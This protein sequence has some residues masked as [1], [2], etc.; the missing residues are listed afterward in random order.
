MFHQRWYK[1]TPYLAPLRALVFTVVVVRLPGA[2]V[3]VFLV[4]TGAGV[5]V[6]LFLLA[7]AHARRIR[8]STQ[9]LHRA[10]E[11]HEHL[12]A[13][14]EQHRKKLNELISQMPGVVWEMHRQGGDLA[15]TF[16]SGY[17]EKLLGYTVADWVD[18]PGFWLKALHP[19]DRDRVLNDIAHVFETGAGGSKFR[20]IAKDGRV[21]WVE[22]HAAV[23][24]DA[25]GN[26][27]GI[28]GVSMD[29]TARHRAEETLRDK[30]QRLQIALSAARMASWHWD[31]VT[32]SLIWDDASYTWTEFVKRVHADDQSTVLQA[33][34]QALQERQDVDIEFR[35]VQPD[36]A[37][38]WLVLKAKV[39][40]GEDGRPA[41]ITGVSI[42]VS[43]RRKAAEA[44]RTSEE[45]YRLAARATNDAIWDWDLA[46]GLVQ[47]NEGVRALF[48]YSAEQ[49]GQDIAW[50][51]EQIHEDDRERV[52]SGI[53]AV[54]KGGGRF[55]SDEYRFRCANGSYA[56][57]TDR[58]YID[59]NESGEAVRV[60]AAMTDVTRLKQ[61]ERERE[62]LLRLEQAARK[63]AEAASRLKDEFLATLSH[64]LRTPITPILGWTHLLRS[65][66]SDPPQLER[67]LTVIEQNARS[68]AKLIEDLLDVS[69]IVTGKMQLKMQPVQLERILR[70][71]IDSVQTAADAKRVRIETSVDQL[72]DS[73]AADPDRLQQVLWNLLSNAIKFTPGGGV[74]RILL[75]TAGNEIRV[76]VSD[77]GEGIPSEFLPH[78]FDRFSQADSTLIRAHGGLGVGLAIVRYIVELHGGRVNV[79]SLG[80]G[81]G[82]TFTVFL[83]ITNVETARKVKKAKP[84]F[85]RTAP[86]LQDLRLLLVD[87]EP[88]ARELITLML[89]QEGAVVTAAE[90]S[91]EALEILNANPPDVLISDIAMPGENGYVLLEK[92]RDMEHELGRPPTP[93]I[94]LTAFARDEDRKH[95]LQVGFAAHIAKPIEIEKLV[96]V[97][98]GI[99]SKHMG[100]AG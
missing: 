91:S 26:G 75:E 59:Q 82:A 21:V 64:E 100:K 85:L 4:S 35:V 15:T 77:T 43:D 73:I 83:P 8:E 50:R 74:I 60:I 27:I 49:I 46:T 5:C 57:V 6:V 3:N 48:G 16:I 51:W 12:S 62:Q 66:G 47:W 1:V 92:L 52:V 44:L 65:R 90:S 53:D 70:A 34:D 86:N 17:V 9:Q 13:Q 99:A 89:Q 87:D 67:G 94:A 10:N 63:Q 71:A 19:E 24:L 31:L 93:A 37:T 88:D 41:Y 38:H 78:V 14:L 79:E 69:R 20:W 68:Q 2:R 61:I 29:I 98:L 45:R 28:R 97:I 30:E 40:Q 80:K 76:V 72:P 36:D 56:T 39:F 7:R 25:E 11:L 23:L 22:T 33:I 42:E 18:E 32:G 95:A 58:A 96:S 84:R 55:W 54:V 81:R